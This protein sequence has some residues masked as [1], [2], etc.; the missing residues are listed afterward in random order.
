MPAGC[1]PA[2]PVAVD[3]LLAHA[4]FALSYAATPHVC[5]KQHDA[6]S[7]AQHVFARR[8]NVRLHCHVIQLHHGL[9]L[10]CLCTHIGCGAGG[11]LAA[12]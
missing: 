3:V 5:N 6:L 9:Y 4:C 1:V 7:H 8:P 11:M 10:I 12:Y 2:L